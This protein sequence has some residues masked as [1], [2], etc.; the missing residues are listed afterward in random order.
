MPKG[1][2]HFFKIDSVSGILVKE[3][4]NISGLQFMLFH[5][6]VC[7]RILGGCKA[8]VGKMCRFCSKSTGS[9]PE[10][11]EKLPN[12]EAKFWVGGPAGNPEAV[13]PVGPFVG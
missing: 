1:N 5:N 9:I 11:N 10:F 3:H 6:S 4:R 8:L 13:G 7:N 12:L 2:R